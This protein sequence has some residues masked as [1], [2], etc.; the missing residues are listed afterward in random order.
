VEV[1]TVAE[2]SDYYRIP[3]S[4]ISGESVPRFPAEA[5][6]SIAG[7]VRAQLAHV[8]ALRAWPVDVEQGAF[9]PTILRSAARRRS[10]HLVVGLSEPGSS[11][12]WSGRESLQKVVQLSHVPVLALPAGAA[13]LPSS[14]VVAL[15]FSRFSFQAAWQ[16]AKVLG[17]SAELHLAHV[18]PEPSEEG[19]SWDSRYEWTDRC[20]P[21]VLRRLDALASALR[22][23]ADV[24][25]HLHR[26]SGTPARA[27]LGLVEDVQAGLVAF[28]SHGHGYLGRACIGGTCVRLLRGT[29]AAVLVV[30]P[31]GIPDELVRDPRS[32]SS[33]MLEQE[34]EYNA[35][36]AATQ[37]GARPVD[38]LLRRH[39]QRESP[40]RASAERDVS[41]L[42]ESSRG[43]G[44]KP[45]PLLPRARAAGS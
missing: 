33:A 21:G 17:P 8:R 3:M 25:I 6:G 14:A 24:T 15:D 18:L 37:S 1:L 27:L 12:T 31:T 26:L 20:R 41:A 29:R 2:P 23:V 16:A 43:A 22:G 36:L 34:M 7:R 44:S 13:T 38:R 39:R 28:G 9:A 10:T 30:P 45:Q 5:I 42:G 40:A 32:A 19:E 35:F 11:G 4:G